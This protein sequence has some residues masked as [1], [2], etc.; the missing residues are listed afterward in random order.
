MNVSRLPLPFIFLFTL[1]LMSCSTSSNVAIVSSQDVSDLPLAVVNGQEITLEEFDYQFSRTS[2]SSGSAPYDSLEALEDFLTRYVDFKVKVLEAREAGYHLLPELNSEIGQYRTQLAR[3]FLLERN[4]FE[5]LVQ[6]MYDRR[7]EAVDASHILLTVAE[8]AAPADTATAYSQISSIRDS[9]LTGA[10]FGALAM[11]YSNDPSANGAPGSPGYQGSL[12]FF[13]GGRMVDSFENQAFATRVGGVSPVFRSQFGYH[14]LKV[15]DRRVMPDD[16]L[17]AHIMI[18]PRG[19]AAADAADLDQRLSAVITQLKAGEE[20]AKVANE[21]SDDRQSAEKGGELGV[22]SYDAGL[23][24][25]FRDAGFSIE[26]PGDYVG[27]VQTSFGY[28]FIKLVEVLPLGSFEEAYEDLKSQVSRLPRAA[29]AEKA[30]AVRLRNQLGYWI[31]S[32]MV[33]RWTTSITEDSLFRMLIQKA[34][35]ASDS[36]HVL[37]KLGDMNFTV[38][39]FSNFL[40]SGKIPD[41]QK[42][43]PRLYTIAEEFLNQE[44]LNHEIEILEARETEFARTMQD[45]RD[46]L[47]LF[48]LMEDS[49]WTAS[50]A[51][52]VGLLAYYESNKTEYSFPDRIRVLS[53]SA[54]SDSLIKGVITRYRGETA[55]AAKLWAQGVPNQAIRVDTTFVEERSGSIYDQVFDMQLG[56]ISDPTPYNRGFIALAHAGTDPSHPMTFDDARAVLLNSYQAEIENRLLQR[57]RAKYGVHVYPERLKAH[58]TSTAASQ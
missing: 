53:F 24:F 40:S 22:I 54:V 47:I 57:L 5:P 32:T 23:P 19:Q 48:R 28:H 8:N 11:K 45:F 4:V 12:G 25:S 37:L 36:S 6:E 41:A 56:E 1:G 7:K 34:Y 51:D 58:L 29:A 3:P 39:Q 43:Q 33:N 38:S 15:N 46:G 31:D 14:I 44:A 13:G 17:L 55:D 49:V 26:K 18:R 2:A 50:S 10:D 27:P 9:V 16:R 42:S 20:F 30:F 35:S 52:S 21:M